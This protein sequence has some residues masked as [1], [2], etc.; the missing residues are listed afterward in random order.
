ML[1]YSKNIDALSGDIKLHRKQSTPFSE[2]F[3]DLS[4]RGNLKTYR[5]IGLLLLF[6]KIS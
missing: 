5:D 2:K 1:P 3:L 6:M 4:V